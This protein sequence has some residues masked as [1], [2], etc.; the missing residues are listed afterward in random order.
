[1]TPTDTLFRSTLATVTA[2]H[3]LLLCFCCFQ[4][5]P[6]SKPIK[7]TPRVSKLTIQTVTL[8]PEKAPSLHT[9]DNDKELK[10]EPPSQKSQKEEKIKVEAPKPVEAEKKEPP[11]K[12]A[13]PVKIEKPSPPKPTLKTTVAPKKNVPVKTTPKPPPKASNVQKPLKPHPPKEKASATKPMPS[14]TPPPTTIRSQL[15]KKAQEHLKEAK[16]SNQALPPSQTHVEA[17]KLIGSL[18]SDTVASLASSSSDAPTS[19]EDQLVLRLKTLLKLPEYGNVDIE[20]TLASS[21]KLLDFKIIRDGSK[22]NRAYVEKAI[23]GASFP[24]FGK[25]LGSRLKHTFAIT[26]CNDI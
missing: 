7:S 9:N 10:A 19:Y 4:I 14:S 17:P 2:A 11:L 8:T 1:M 24:P 6:L 16:A 3:V 25:Q 20:L 13:P 26:L 5:L 12:Q 23:K 15:L 18:Q 21:G 22:I